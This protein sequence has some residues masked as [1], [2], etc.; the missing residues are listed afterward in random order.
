MKF[1]QNGCILKLKVGEEPRY[2]RAEP[3]AVNRISAHLKARMSI[4]VDWFTKRGI[5]PV[6]AGI[7]D[8][9]AGFSI[10]EFFMAIVSLVNVKFRN[11][12]QTALL[13]LATGFSDVYLHLPYGDVRGLPSL[14]T[15]IKSFLD[16]LVGFE[17]RDY[18]TI[19]HG[20]RAAVFMA[21]KAQMGFMKETLAEI[22]L[23][24]IRPLQG[25]VNIED[26]EKIVAKYTGDKKKPRLCATE[27]LAAWA[28][29][30]ENKTIKAILLRYV[31]PQV[32]VPVP[33]WGT[34]PNIIQQALGDDCYVPILSPNGLLDSE[35]LAKLCA[36]NP[37]IRMLVFCNPVNPTG[38]V[39]GSDR[40]AGICRVLY[41]HQLAC[42]ADDMYAMFAWQHEHRS[43]LR[44]AAA[45][46]HSGEAEIGMWVA[47]HTTMM[48][49]VMKA[50]GSGSRVNFT[51]I[52]ND[53]LRSR[54]VAIQ[55][56]L[57]GPPPIFSQLLQLVFIQSGGPER[58]WAEL[59]KRRD[60]LQKILEHIA[61]KLAGVGIE[62]SWTPMEGGFYTVISCKGVKGLKW[63]TPEGHER[64]IDNGEAFA[65]CLLELG[66]LVVT[67][68]A[69][70]CISDVEFAR[71]AYGTLSCFSMD[72]MEKQLPAALEELA[73]YNSNPVKLRIVSSATNA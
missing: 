53:F 47:G 48:C 44:A 38:V 3:P 62:F 65:D 26:L 66:G 32:V 37:R 31:R 14:L 54:Y 1:Y 8:C 52:P 33:T 34:Y 13:A 35:K 30:A 4:L 56:D 5:K 55:G 10:V 61:G 42:H 18:L 28:E 58:V 73:G 70:A 17:V 59:L 71:I 29:G 21:I 24:A 39:Y 27:I 69:A 63:M 36:A 25:K 41:E 19:T 49:G 51:I 40:M 12:L 46:A 9:D 23:E 50:G 6:E 16:V 68:D 64:V 60:R 7:G 11:A 67:P 57:Y 2:S 72:V 22:A 45:L 20:G 43:I 15:G